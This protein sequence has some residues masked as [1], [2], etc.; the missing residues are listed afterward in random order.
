MPL[1]GVNVGGEKVVWDRVT[2]DVLSPEIIAAMSDQTGRGGL[3]MSD[4]FGCPRNV[5]RQKRYGYYVPVRSAY[6]MAR[7]K[8]WDALA[9]KYAPIGRQTQGQAKRQLNGVWISGTPDI[10]D[11][12][13]NQIEDYKAPVSDKGY[14]EIPIQYAFQVNAYRWLLQD[15]L[16]VT[17]LQLNVCTQWEYRVME[18]LPIP[19][20][21]VT[22]ELENAIHML[23]E[24]AALPDL[25]EK[26]DQKNCYCNKYNDTL[27]DY[28]DVSPWGV[29]DMEKD[30]D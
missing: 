2:P 3:H 21:E 17:R 22:M 15:T 10:I 18:V 28:E 26:C 30:D 23:R 7:G 25:V 9:E 16:E 20:W 5:V 11:H 29:I 12:V 27:W 13:H 8:A 6:W 24:T 4:L 14:Q 1:R 19:L